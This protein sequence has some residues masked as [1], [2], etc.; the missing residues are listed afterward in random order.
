MSRSDFGIIE[1]ISAQESFFQ[2]GNGVIRCGGRL[3]DQNVDDLRDQILT[4]AHSCRYSIHLKA[5]KM[6]HELREVYSL[7]VM[8]K[9]ITICVA[10]CSNY[11]Q[12]K[13]DHHKLGYSWH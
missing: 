4:D 2:W 12:V 1:W 9:D 6:Y 11:Q 7:N 5:T 10:N 8:K 13:F 3:Y